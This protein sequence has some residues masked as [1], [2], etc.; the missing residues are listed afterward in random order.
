[1]KT[2]T[3]RYI[4]SQSYPRTTRVQYM[5]A[6]TFLLISASSMRMGGVAP[7]E[8]R[9]L[10]GVDPLETRPQEM[11]LAV[12]TGIV[13]TVS[14]L[15]VGCE[16]PP[17]F[18][19]QSPSSSNS[20]SE[21]DRMFVGPLSS[22]FDLL[23]AD[24]VV[25]VLPRFLSTT[26]DGGSLCRTSFSFLQKIA[27][28]I[29]SISQDKED[30]QPPLGLKKGHS[31]SSSS[32]HVQ[33]ESDQTHLSIVFREVFTEGHT[34]LDLLDMG[35]DMTAGDMERPGPDPSSGAVEAH[36]FLQINAITH[37]YCCEGSE[38]NQKISQSRNSVCAVS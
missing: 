12:R 29:P 6:H 38:P 20:M 2:L 9:P 15:V 32:F 35:G 27:V 24:S 28:T 7:L 36:L 25:A 10:G 18:S 31:K 33:E 3:L 21:R 30:R 11:P 1:M 5:H 17:P 14:V 37:G 16:T 26:A 22:T 4:R 13:G 8:T 23:T 19:I 34:Y